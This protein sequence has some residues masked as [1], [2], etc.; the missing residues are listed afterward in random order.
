MGLLG[1]A[2]RIMI[3]IYARPQLMT[4]MPFL[5]RE[6]VQ[7]EQLNLIGGPRPFVKEVPAP[8][9]RTD[10]HVF[11]AL[12]VGIAVETGVAKY[13]A[14]KRPGA[15][16]VGVGSPDGHSSLAVIGRGRLRHQRADVSELPAVREPIHTQ[17][18]QVPRRKHRLEGCQR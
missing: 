14:Q 7:R 8:A 17:R 15:E 2:V 9:L 10:Q 3:E 5:Q 13:G 11:W 4:A 6:L 18:Q 16:L 12:A 1:A